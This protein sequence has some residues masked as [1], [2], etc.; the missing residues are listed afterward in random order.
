MT[1][2]EKQGQVKRWMRVHREAKERKMVID[3]PSMCVGI[4]VGIGII[5]GLIGLSGKPK[6]EP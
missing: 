6:V 5:L 1:D 3:F 2:D 4:I